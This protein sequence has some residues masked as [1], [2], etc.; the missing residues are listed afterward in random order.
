MFP[1]GNKAELYC[2]STV[3]VK[4]YFISTLESKKCTA[5]KSGYEIQSVAIQI[6][7]TVMNSKVFCFTQW[8]YK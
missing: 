7:V 8:A 1:H 4:H 2:D 5:A 6:L 3:K